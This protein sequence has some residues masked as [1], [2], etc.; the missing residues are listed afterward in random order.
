MGRLAFIGLIFLLAAPACGKSSAT[1]PSGVSANSLTAAIDG[2]QRNF[3]PVTTTQAP[4]GATQT[5]LTIN[6]L[7]DTYVL[8]ITARHDGRAIT[9]PV[10]LATAA[11]TLQIL[12]TGQVW[13][14]NFMTAGS[15]GAVQFSTLTSNRAVGTFTFTTV[16][17]VGSSVTSGTKSFNGQFNVTF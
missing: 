11:T 5:V 10:S 6:G 2:A 14:A 4:A 15:S 17:E 16:P 13:I 9:Y 3:T 12:G 8:S 7:A 1:G